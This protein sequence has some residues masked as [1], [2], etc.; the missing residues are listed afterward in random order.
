M[1]Y[2]PWKVMKIK[3]FNNNNNKKI[4]HNIAMSEKD[5]VGLVNTTL[6]SLKTLKEHAIR[7][8][9]GINDKEN[10]MTMK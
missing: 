9:N 5:A 6:I 10:E 2:V 1:L 3:C 4:H 8:F 7:L